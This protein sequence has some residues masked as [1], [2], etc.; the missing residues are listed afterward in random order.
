MQATM[1]MIKA[2]DIDLPLQYE[3]FRD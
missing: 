2:L 3:N 1:A